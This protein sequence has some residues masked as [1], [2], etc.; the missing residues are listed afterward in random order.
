MN[1]L[2]WHCTVPVEVELKDSSDR[3]FRLTD[4]VTGRTVPSFRKGHWLYF[5]APDLP[6]LGFKKFETAAGSDGTRI[7]GTSDLRMT[8]SSIE[9]SSYRIRADH[10]TGQITSIVDKHQQRELVRAGGIPFGGPVVQRGYMDQTFEPIHATGVTIAVDDE[11]PV[12]LVLSLL[13]PGEVVEKTE[14][15]LWSGVDRIDIAHTVHLDAL[16]PPPEVEVFATGF[17]L[18]FSGTATPY[19]D[20]LG[21]FLRGPAERLAGA[22]TDVYSI[23]RAA[24]LSDGATSVSFAAADSRIVFWRYDSLSGSSTLL[25]N[26]VTNFP[27]AWNRNESNAGRLRLRFALS[28]N[29]GPFDPDMTTRLGWEM[30]TDFFSRPTLIRR[31]PAQQSYL[32]VTGNSAVLSGLKRGSAPGETVLRITNVD[33]VNTTRATLSSSVFLPGR[34]TQATMF[35]RP[36]KMLSIAD[37]TATIDLGPSE[38][39]TLLIQ[40]N[41]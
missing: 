21:G 8:E 33:P 24:A 40:K 30:Q 28:S 17:P 41:P 32:S 29:T 1:P 9:N 6:P 13:R 11:R 31:V 3:Q 36:G 27:V 18:S 34:I 35:E 22:L 7:P 25:A 10:E 23:R 26:L 15:I 38:T 37:S 2:A 12:R 4:L 5:V 20:I 14:Y 16:R 19:M 39:K